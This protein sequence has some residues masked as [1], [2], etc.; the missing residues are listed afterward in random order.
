MF[1]HNLTYHSSK[2]VS[3]DKNVW[4]IK[5]SKKLYERVK[6]SL[7]SRRVKEEF[8]TIDDTVVDEML[9]KGR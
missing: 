8:P 6:N 9:S 4:L 5:P 3:S 2:W 1:Y 7:W